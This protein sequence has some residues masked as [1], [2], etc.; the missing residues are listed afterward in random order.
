MLFPGNGF[1]LRLPDNF[2]LMLRRGEE[3][4]TGVGGE[5]RIEAGD[6]TIIYAKPEDVAKG[7]HLF[8]RQKDRQ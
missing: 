6:S 3:V 2:V 7:T 1:L 5:T 8:T 4:I